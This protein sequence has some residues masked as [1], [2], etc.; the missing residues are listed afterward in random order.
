ML[1]TILLVIVAIIAI[2]VLLASRQ[3]DSFR[4]AR[5]ATVQAPPERVFALI[6]DFQ[7]WL[8][9]SPWEKLDP[10]MKKD[11][12]GPPSG[13]GSTY[14]WSGNSK[15]GEGRMEIVESEPPS[16][17]KLD[18]NFI[19]PFKSSNTT[20]FDLAPSGTGTNVNWTMNGSANL[21][22]KIWMLFVNMDKMVG[23]DFDEGLMN[24]KRVAEQS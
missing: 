12:G 17:V 14:G 3:P 20:Q 19:R 8:K 10:A 13:V 7:N 5:T 9:W 4:V 22:T 24:L 1:M 16:R 11:F 21:M 23:R 2:I 15:A 6:N 18:L